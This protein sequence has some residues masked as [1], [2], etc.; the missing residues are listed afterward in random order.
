M[1]AGVA[2]GLLLDES[3]G[4]G[5]PLILTDILG[6]EDALGT[7][8]FKVA[9]DGEGVSAFQLDIKCEG[10]SLPLMRRALEQAKSGRLHILQC[11][12]EPADQQGVGQATTVSQEAGRDSIWPSQGNDRAQMGPGPKWA[13]GPSGL[14]A[15]ADPGPKW[16]L[17]PNG[18]WA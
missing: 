18:P 14:W 4:G 12:Q 10:L 5:E 11:M 3:G 15:Q 17:G 16:A 2:M 7:M 13:L 6:S 8:D 1:V 9:G